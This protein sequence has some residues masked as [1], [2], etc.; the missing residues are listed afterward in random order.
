M[1]IKIPC[2]KTKILTFFL[3]LFLLYP[4]R[5]FSQVSVIRYIDSVMTTKHKIIKRFYANKNGFSITEEKH[6]N[7]NNI[8]EITFINGKLSNIDS[9]SLNYTIVRNNK[10]WI[11]LTSTFEND[12]TY[13]T[14][15]KKD[16]VVVKYK[17]G[18]ITKCHIELP[19]MKAKQ[20]FK[21]IW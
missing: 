16:G 9:D 11:N 3:L 1:Y 2:I 4:V 17:E 6:F 8:T 7:K 10:F 14:T 18:E 20:F 13:H 21:E 15:R 19:I 12:F 5:I